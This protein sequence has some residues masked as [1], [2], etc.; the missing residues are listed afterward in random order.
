MEMSLH[1]W[2]PGEMMSSSNEGKTAPFANQVLPLYKGPMLKHSHHRQMQPTTGAG[3]GNIIGGFQIILDALYGSDAWMNW[4][5]QGFNLVQN[6]LPAAQ[7]Y[8]MNDTKPGCADTWSDPMDDIMETTR[9]LALRASL[10][11]ASQNT[12]NTQEVSYTNSVT[13]LVYV[14]DYS[15]MRVAVAISLIGLVAVL[16][17]FWGWWDLGR[18][19][20]LNPL[21]AANAFGAFVPTSSIP[22]RMDPNADMKSITSHSKTVG[23]IRYGAYSRPTGSVGLGFGPARGTR[24]PGENEGF[25]F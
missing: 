21:E 11:Y 2:E 8:H 25:Q 5:V 20:S 22:S 7:Y 14:T 6:G 10:L 16:P 1:R 19:V 24:K 23:Q 17:V 15:K 18:E 4:K 13:V 9:Q 3:V 12:S